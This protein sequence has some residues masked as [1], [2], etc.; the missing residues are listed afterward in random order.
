MR[1]IT[2]KLA[3]AKITTPPQTQRH[4][5]TEF[6]PIEYLMIDVAGHFGLDKESFK[7]R[8]WWT[9]N[10]RDDILLMLYEVEAAAAEGRKQRPTLMDQAETPA[11][12]YAA[13]RAL[14]MAEDGYPI[15]F[16]ISLDATA[17]GIQLLAI[18]AG[19]RKTAEICNV[20]PTGTRRDAY[21]HIYNIMNLRLGTKGRV[22]RKDVKAAT[23]TAFYGSTAMPKQVFGK[24]EL[25]E[26]F[27]E[28]IAETAMGAWQL[29]LELPTLW[30]PNALSH[31]W[32][33][34]DNFHCKIKV[35]AMN[36]EFIHVEG[37][38][39]EVR[40]KVNRPIPESRSLCPNLVHSIDGLVVREMHRRCTY[41]QAD[42][43][44]CMDAL[45]R[46]L[47]G[48]AVGKGT[49]NKNDKLVAEL[50]A[51]ETRTGFFSTRILSVL[52]LDNIGHLSHDQIRALKKMLH[53]LPEKPFP[54]MSI[55]D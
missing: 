13:C 34:P 23:M 35:E 15:S 21:T 17:S 53:S 40:Y 11:L 10:H 20:V 4:T 3:H 30:N 55:H 36:R 44:R 31:D 12:F 9:D 33:L 39:L 27:Y 8:I 47:R 29:N 6:T 14:R 28:V 18:L 32:V 22:H 45:K 42:Y 38:P 24:G 46:Y 7:H 41:E 5:F 2:H 1:S 52:S 51:L 54:I 48:H 50:C 25:L 43:S 19:C 37:A 49:K 16:P 26:L